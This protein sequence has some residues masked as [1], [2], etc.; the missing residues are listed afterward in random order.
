MSMI[1]ILEI[2]QSQAVIIEIGF[3]GPPGRDAALPAGQPGQVMGYD[4]EGN[5]IA[6]DPAQASLPPVIDLGTFN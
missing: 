2:I 1:V 5:L 4:A 3:Q 6:I